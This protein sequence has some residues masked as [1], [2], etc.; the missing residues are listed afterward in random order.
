MAPQVR[1]HWDSGVDVDQASAL[2]IGGL[3]RVD[4]N[5]TQSVLGYT[6]HFGEV[7]VLV[8]VRCRNNFVALD[9][10]RYVLALLEEEEHEDSHDGHEYSAVPE[11]PSPALVHGHV[12]G[13][14]GTK[15]VARDDEAEVD[16]VHSGALVNEEEVG[17]LWGKMRNQLRCILYD[18]LSGFQTYRD[19]EDGLIHGASKARDGI[20]SNH[21]ADRL[22]LGL[23]DGRGEHDQGGEEVYWTSSESKSDRDEEN[24]PY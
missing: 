21:V 4:G 13:G 23:P 15:V 6:A 1:V 10:F 17:D 20:A 3:C 19:L 16:G 7:M 24:A 9:D 8:V 5:R 12:P 18:C 2:I 14:D 22:H 11:Y